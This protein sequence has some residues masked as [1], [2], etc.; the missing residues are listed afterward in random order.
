MEAGPARGL[1]YGLRLVEAG[2]KQNAMKRCGAAMVAAGLLLSSAPALGAGANDEMKQAAQQMLEKGNQQYSAG[3]YKD[4]LRQFQLAYLTY[5]SAKLLYNMGQCELAL[6]H[7]AEAATAFR[8]FLIE[9]GQDGTFKNERASAEVQV[10][11]LAPS[12]GQLHIRVSPEEGDV[13]VDDQT[14]DRRDALNLFLPPGPHRLEASA[15]LYKPAAQA[16]S[17]AAGEDKQLV[18]TLS[19]IL[20]ESQDPKKLDPVDLGQEERDDTVPKTVGYVVLGTG[21]L[22]VGVGLVSWALAAT[23]S[24]ELHDKV[25]GN[26]GSDGLGSP[27]E[28]GK[29]QT[30][31]VNPLRSKVHTRGQVAAIGLGVGAGLMLVGAGFEL[32]PRFLH[33]RPAAAPEVEQV[34]LEPWLSPGQVGVKGS[35]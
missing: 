28:P 22:G 18:L 19:P 33:G 21:A 4:A 7:P 9:A 2:M 24:K 5:P 35:F 29:L 1:G 11:N 17:L 32:L 8:R 23:A 16:F 10:A 20:V 13:R 27:I 31:S 25:Q 14:V 6:K 15:R 30:D 3:K 26:F 12:L 34:R